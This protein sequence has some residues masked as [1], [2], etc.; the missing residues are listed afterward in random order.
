MI[1]MTFLREIAV[2]CEAQYKVFWKNEL[3]F[4]LREPRRI[5]ATV[6]TGPG[7]HPASCKIGT[8]LSRG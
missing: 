7:A 2:S 6:Q 3:L 1:S 4:Y 8:G 5:S